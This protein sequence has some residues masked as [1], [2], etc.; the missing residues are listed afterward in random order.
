MTQST[1]PQILPTGEEMDAVE[2]TTPLLTQSRE[3]LH[4]AERVGQAL[5]A[6]GY[7]PLRGITVS[8]HAR[9][10]RLGGR[11]PNYYLKQIAQTTALAV[12]GIHQIH[13]DLEVVQLS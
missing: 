12:P 9:I 13:N 5:R 11:V 2:A 10:V 7:G 4:L 3:D 6:T 1:A 8:V